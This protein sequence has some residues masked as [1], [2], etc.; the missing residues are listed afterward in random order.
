MMS[1]TAEDTK[2]AIFMLLPY[3]I[4]CFCQ[5]GTFISAQIGQKGDAG[6]PQDQPRGMAR[7]LSPVLIAPEC[8]LKDVLSSI[9]GHK[10]LLWPVA[11]TSTV[12]T[13]SSFSTD[14][15]VLKAGRE[16]ISLNYVSLTYRRRY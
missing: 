11:F 12:V 6:P 13:I 9:P 8:P 16:N 1:R 3:I 14:W 4:V 5:S 7:W 10:M 15:Q 2:L